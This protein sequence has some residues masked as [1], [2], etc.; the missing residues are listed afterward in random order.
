[1]S[2]VKPLEAGPLQKEEEDGHVL[3]FPVTEPGH[4]LAH[5][6]VWGEVVRRQD[7]DERGG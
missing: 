2:P 4:L 1:M 5:L 7:A 3:F 6:V